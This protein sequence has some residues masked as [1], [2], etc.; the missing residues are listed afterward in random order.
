MAYHCGTSTPATP[1]SAK[2][3][4]SG[5]AAIRLD[6]ATATAWIAPDFRC[7]YTLNRL[8]NITCVTPAKVSFSAGAEPL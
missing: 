2:V 7:G 5:S 3:G 8:G 4:R 6:P 1:A